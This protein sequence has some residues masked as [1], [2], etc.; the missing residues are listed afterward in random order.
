M[1]Y[2][3]SLSSL[4]AFAKQCIDADRFPNDY[5]S[6]NP[7][8]CPRCGVVPLELTIEHHTGSKQGD[9]KGL[10]FACCAQCQNTTPIFSFTNSNR[11]PTYEDKPVCTCS[12]VSFLVGECE[13]IEREDGLLG[14]FDEGVVVGQCAECGQQQAFVYTD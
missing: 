1:K 6:F 2:S 14:F 12:G 13:R 9:F 3:A 7:A 4:K 11:H 8:R 10:I 5:H